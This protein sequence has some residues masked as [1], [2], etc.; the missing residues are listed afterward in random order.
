MYKERFYI[1]VLS[2]AQH[3]FFTVDT[4]LAHQNETK[5][6]YKR[7]HARKNKDHTHVCLRWH[8]R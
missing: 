1:C 8:C 5:A 6:Q 2:G 3:V 7:R 4:Q